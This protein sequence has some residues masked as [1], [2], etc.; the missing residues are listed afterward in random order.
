M[1]LTDS[2]CRAPNSTGKREKRFDGRGLYLDVMP[3]G[4]KQWRL[5][6]RYDGRSLV[7]SIGPYPKVSLAAARLARSLAL[8]KLAAG[9]NPGAK[10]EAPKRAPDAGRTFEAVAEDWL[11]VQAPGWGEAHAKR[12]TARVRSNLIRPLGRMPVRSLTAQDC[13]SAIRPIE[14]RG[15]LDIARRAYQSLCAILDFAVAAGE[16]DVNPAGSIGKALKARPRVRH[17]PMILGREVP[18]LFERLCAYEGEPE[19]VLA[20][21]AILHTGL[22]TTELRLGQWSEIESDRWRIPEA[23]MKVPSEHLVPLTPGLRRI[24]R[25]AKALHPTSSWIFPGPRG[26]PISENTMIYALYRMGYK[27]KLTVDGLRRTFSTILNETGLFEPDWI[28]KQLAHEERNKVRA[29]Y[30]SAEYWEHRVK[31]MTWWS[32]YLR[33]AEV[34]KLL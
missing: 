16:A 19:T 8:D 27:D 21:R 13:L 30:N 14:A 31:M 24:L 32:G 28:E 1:K 15:A 26:K 7:L 25:A 2:H 6:Y 4:A 18:E 22:R 10:A 34:G 12:T 9:Q 20:I 33:R 17:H 5:A 29:A 3:G 23:R 11:T